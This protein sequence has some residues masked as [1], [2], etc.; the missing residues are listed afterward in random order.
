[1]FVNRAEC[2]QKFYTRP[3]F[4]N[5]RSFLRLLCVYAD[6]HNICAVAVNV[7]GLGKCRPVVAGIFLMTTIEPLCVTFL[8]LI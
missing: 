2:T 1:M 3:T 8:S 6:K 7:V 4:M 5:Q